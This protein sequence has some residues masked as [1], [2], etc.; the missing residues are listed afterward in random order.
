ME[1]PSTVTVMVIL[2]IFSL[3][4]TIGNS[5]VLYIYTHKKEKST[6]GIFI[7]SLAGT[8]LFTCLFIMPYTEIVIYLQYQLQFDAACKVYMF[9]ITCN[10]PFAAFIMV[11]IAT[12]RYFCICH[13]FLHA[14]NIKR[15]KIIVLCLLA[16]A[17]SFGVITALMHGVYMPA[18]QFNANSNNSMDV[19]TLNVSDLP[20]NQ[21]ILITS[22]NSINNTGYSIS[23]NNTFSDV[24]EKCA[25]NS[26]CYI[27]VRKHS[28]SSFS[29][30]ATGATEK[31]VFTGTCQPNM[32]IIG[33]TFVDWYQKVYAG[34][35]LLS[36]FAVVVLYGLIYKSIHEHRAKRSKRKRSSLYP[37]GEQE[38]A[39]YNFSDVMSYEIVDSDEHD[40][41]DFQM[42]K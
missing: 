14:L 24:I 9:F 23:D 37:S 11:A 4:G 19:K 25:Q 12:D 28:N 3:C 7:M 36:F 1:D 6:A 20:L 26:T 16:A 22:F 15:A 2:S 27:D 33:S 10:I 34:V 35:Y 40:C 39:N 38:F 32:I 29:P 21:E 30:Q 31:Y 42:K 13:P 8:D 17:S 18:V 41:S 5:L